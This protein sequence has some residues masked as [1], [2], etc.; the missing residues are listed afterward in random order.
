[1]HENSLEKLS[2][3]AAEQ[4][5][6]L[7]G[8]FELTRRCNL[9]CRFCYVCDRSV[10]A[11]EAPEKTADEWLYMI[12]KAADAGMFVCTFT[13]GEPF[14]R[15][16]FEE[17]YCKTYDI[18]LRVAIFTNATLIGHKQMAYLQKRV[19]LFVSISLYGASPESY[20][21]ICGSEEAYHLSQSA[22]SKLCGA[23]ITV[24]LKTLALRPLMDEY[25]AIGHV[26]AACHCPGAID[27]YLGPGRDDPN[28]ESRRWRIPMDRIPAAIA[29]FARGAGIPPEDSLAEKTQAPPSGWNLPAILC[30]AGKSAFTITH[31][32]R[33]LGCPT[34]TCFESHP[35]ADGFTAAWA[36][37]RDQVEHAQP[38]LECESCP[39]IHSCLLC[40]ANRV[41]E[42]GSVSRC[43]AYLK[44]LACALD[45]KN[46][47]G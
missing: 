20:R 10:Q 44:R 8:M 32:G 19:P 4:G 28:R 33:M 7:N 3:Y 21:L 47:A 16:D 5:I 17:I 1:M 31:D 9:R 11:R 45:V 42:T 39:H 38:C 35:F 27:V 24:K 46:S 23:G 15:E 18:G 6:P 13:G 41:K 2:R 36:H 26:A 12:R 29:A 22:I 37:L 43:S 34:L 30:R 25:E 14:L 40:A